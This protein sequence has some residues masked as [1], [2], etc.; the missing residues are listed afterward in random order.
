MTDC[1][2][3]M[4]QVGSLHN[5]FHSMGDM[6]FKAVND[7]KEDNAKKLYEEAS[8]LSGKLLGAL[9]EAEESIAAMSENGEKV[10]S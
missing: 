7:K 6:V 5:A 9:A 10:F 8:E 4:N 2:Y 1:A 3:L